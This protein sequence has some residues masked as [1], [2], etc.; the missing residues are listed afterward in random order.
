LASFHRN[1]GVV[2]RGISNTLL[3]LAGLAQET[4]SVTDN[5]GKVK[6][7]AKN[8]DALP[9]LVKLTPEGMNANQFYQMI[10]RVNTNNYDL[11][12]KAKEEGIRY[13]TENLLFFMK[14]DYNITK[15]DKKAIINMRTDMNPDYANNYGAISWFA[16][17]CEETD[18]NN[19][20]TATSAFI[21]QKLNSLSANGKW[22]LIYDTIREIDNE[23]VIKAF[24]NE[25]RKYFQKSNLPK[26]S[27]ENVEKLITKPETIPAFEIIFSL[28]DH[29][30]DK[31]N[32][33]GEY[34]LGAI[35]AQNAL[36][37]LSADGKWEALQ[38]E[39]IRIYKNIKK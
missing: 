10:V 1:Y 13:E 21:R 5:T 35:A 30:K 12:Q 18:S 17:L 29:A 25:T 26:L 7:K 31:S 23:R 9:T 14:E 28:A 3:K 39:I 16:D 33:N 32:V 6:F 19:R 34:S 38:A 2:W 36:E 4:I 22:Q 8:P 27:K 24:G 37:N 20:P 11:V 15:L